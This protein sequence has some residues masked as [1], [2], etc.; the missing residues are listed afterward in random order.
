MKT[1]VILY[2][3][4]CPDGFSGAWAAWKKFGAAA[5]YVPLEHNAHVPDGLDGANAYFI[6]ILSPLPQ[7]KKVLRKARAVTAIDHHATNRSLVRLI[8]RRSFDVKHSGAV[9]AWKY[10]HRGKPVPKL[11]RH[12]EDVDLWKLKLPHAREI[13]AALELANFNFKTWN[14]IAKDFESSK[15]FRAYVKRGEIILAYQR[16]MIGKIA[17]NAVPGILGKTKVSIV[18]SPI[19]ESELGNALSRHGAPAGL[20]WSEQK[21]VVKVSLRSA[22]KVNV[23]KIAARYGGGGHPFAA[24]FRLPRGA[25]FP[26]NY[27]RGK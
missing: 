12:V 27:K 23:G 6:D 21:N 24:G 2:H 10:F 22:G 16:R 8:R 9:L 17:G 14:A 19:L 26:W 20:V 1:T 15:R 25:P 5:R 13:A 11:L 7:L 3:A 18:N 4:N